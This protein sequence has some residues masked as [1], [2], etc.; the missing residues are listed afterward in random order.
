[1]VSLVLP[2]FVQIRAIPAL[3]VLKAEI[4]KMQTLYVLRFFLPAYVR[5]A[6]ILLNV[7]TAEL[8]L[9]TV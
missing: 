3:S 7:L 2:V 6:H 8:K 9:L 5:A 1:M 4:V